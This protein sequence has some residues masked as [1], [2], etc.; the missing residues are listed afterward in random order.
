M[1]TCAPTYQRIVITFVDVSRI[2][3][4]KDNKER[5]KRKGKKGK[6]KKERKRRKGET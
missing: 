6:E 3:L 2:G 5:K 1:H 4:R